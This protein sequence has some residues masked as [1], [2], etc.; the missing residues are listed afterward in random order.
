[1]AGGQ[2]DLDDSSMMPGY[3]Q[4]RMSGTLWSPS[5]L[6]SLIWVSMGLNMHV[7]TSSLIW[8][9]SE[10]GHHVPEVCGS[11]WGQNSAPAPPF[12][13]GETWGKSLNLSV[14]QCP[15][16]L[17]DRIEIQRCKTLYYSFPAQ[18]T[19]GLQADFPKH[20][21]KLGSYYWLLPQNGWGLT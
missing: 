8:E 21:T 20:G 12:T 13:S 14:C 17:N 1:M 16:K 19:S 11:R 3:L 10:P 15:H 4:V 2:C 18:G 9:K 5:Y 6:V 7:P